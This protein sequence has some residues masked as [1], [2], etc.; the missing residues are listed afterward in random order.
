MLTEKELVKKL[1][2]EA[3]DF[4]ALVKQRQYV[5]AMRRYKTALG[6]AVFVELPREE[7][8]RLF[9]IRG[10]KGVIIQKGA[11]P[12]EMVIKASEMSRAKE[13][14]TAQQKYAERQ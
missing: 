1:H 2:S 12:E 8:D 6:V 10:E 14:K 4:R 3:A 7:L 11:F 13:S 9:G 5:Q